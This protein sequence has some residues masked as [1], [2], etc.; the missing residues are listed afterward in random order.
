MKQEQL[1]KLAKWYG[2]NIDDGYLI[3]KNSEPVAEIR[4]ETEDD[5]WVKH[6][7]L[8][9]PH[10]DSN[11]LDMLEDKMIEE[12]ETLD[13][14]EWCIDDIEGCEEWAVIYQDNF[15]VFAQGIGKTKNEARLD[16]ILNYIE[17]K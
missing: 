14:I 15:Q 4:E 6:L 7:P 16:A 1:K 13:S 2:Y 12:I 5:F 11:Q 10:R 17:N 9:Q 8:W 3:N